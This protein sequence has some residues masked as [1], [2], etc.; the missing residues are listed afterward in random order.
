MARLI[1][2]L[3]LKRPDVLG[4]SM[5]GFVA[6]QLAIRHRGKVRRLILAGTNLGG[7]RAVLGPEWVRQTDSHA[8]SD[9]AALKLLYPMDSRGRREGRRFLDRLVESSR[10]GEIPEDFRVSDGTRAR[11]VAAED[12]WLKSNA[13]RRGLGRLSI[14]ALVTGGRSDL[15]TPPVNAHRIAERIPKAELRLFNGAHAFLFSARQRFAEA[16]RGFLE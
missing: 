13:N 14:P 3:G 2:R 11:Q 9:R 4:W 1:D 10:S 15:T 12:G 8:E 6:Q 16:L 7:D 5:G